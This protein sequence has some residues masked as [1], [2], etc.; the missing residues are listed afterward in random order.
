MSERIDLTLVKPTLYLSEVAF[1][2]N[3]GYRELK[4]GMTG[5]VLEEV[6][7]KNVDVYN[8]ETDEEL[9]DYLKK[10]FTVVAS[11]A[12]ED[13][14]GLNAILF[15]RE[16]DDKYFLTADGMHTAYWWSEM[17]TDGRAVAQYP[18]AFREP[19]SYKLQLTQIVE[20]LRDNLPEGKKVV[21]TGQSLGGTNIT[22]AAM[23]LGDLVEVAI[24][25][26]GPNPTGWATLSD[27]NFI[28]ISRGPSRPDLYGVP[29]GDGTELT[30]EI[31]LSNIDTSMIHQLT[32]KG[33]I[34]AG[35]VILD[36][37]QT[38]GVSIGTNLRFDVDFFDGMSSGEVH[39]LNASRGLLENPRYF[40]EE[41][42][43]TDQVEVVTRTG[44]DLLQ[45]ALDSG[46][47]VKL[48]VSTFS[49]EL[50]YQELVDID[51]GVRRGQD[52]VDQLVDF[53][54]SYSQGTL[55]VPE[56]VYDLKGIQDFVDISFRDATEVTVVHNNDVEN[57]LGKNLP[58]TK[59]GWSQVRQQWATAQV[60]SR[61]RNWEIK[62]LSDT[63][64]IVNWPGRAADSLVLS[65]DGFW[66]RFLPVDPRIVEGLSE[67]T[68]NEEQVPDE[69]GEAIR[70]PRTAVELE[71][72]T[73]EEAKAEV[74]S[75]YENWHFNWISDDQ[76]VVSW[77]GK[78]V[79]S[80]PLS[81]D[82][83]AGRFWRTDVGMKKDAPEEGEEKDQAPDQPGQALKS[84]IDKAAFDVPA[85]AMQHLERMQEAR[86]AEAFPPTDRP[87]M[88]QGRLLLT[89]AQRFLERRGAM[90]IPFQK[91]R[92]PTRAERH[93]EA[94][95]FYGEKMRQ[96]KSAGE[97]QRVREEFV[98][99]HLAID[100]D[101]DQ[102]DRETAWA[103]ATKADPEIGGK[104]L[105]DSLMF[106][107]YALDH[108]GDVELYDFLDDTGLGNHPEVIRM[109]KRVGE[110]AE[111]D[112]T[113]RPMPYRRP[114][115]ENRKR[116][117]TVQ[118]LGMRFHR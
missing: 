10:N 109:F 78:S 12:D 6:L 36:D 100:A 102:R 24:A 28:K 95:A 69:L 19:G 76:V 26:N 71:R 43:F 116:P 70:G 51:A 63:R 106:A 48:K 94:G 113:S 57:L 56:N 17:L 98:A 93:D 42:G 20:F 3:E 8:G 118:W 68:E 29:K 107:R 40:S 61:Y 91:K 74:E 53:V 50:G 79:R 77:P 47:V 110:A 33:D 101:Q 55:P 54:R 97:R 49:R 39:N 73:Y 2:N 7:R 103:Q 67:G 88:P 45:S 30:V 111:G 15:H 92:L 27:G 86:R 22:A 90:W 14:S 21:L 37:A 72:L 96:A 64:V 99:S 38:Q 5:D 44:D 16:S 66:G 60:E 75:A 23:L 117:K 35:R 32:N 105:K 41:S 59:D 25:Y 114:G 34:Y 80:V 11:L 87:H 84:A 31:I 85:A 9:I 62:W 108:F 104:N 1:M 112:R 83:E 4:E 81:Y 115:W 13:N 65:Y 52:G 82:K 58:T 18:D 46:R 89:S